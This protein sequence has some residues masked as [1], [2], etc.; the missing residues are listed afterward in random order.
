[1]RAFFFFLLFVASLSSKESS[2]FTFTEHKLELEGG[3]SFDYEALTGSLPIYQGKQKIADVFFVAYSKAGD[4]PARPM[5]FVLPGGPGAAGTLESLIA[6][7]PRRLLTGGEGRSIL[8]PYPIID[9]PQSLLE[10]TDLVFI[11]PVNCGFSRSVEGEEEKEKD[12]LP[13]LYSVEGDIQSLGQ[14]IQAFVSHFDLWD[15]PKYL[16]GGSYGTLRCCGLALDLLKYDILLSGLLL[17]GCALEWAALD[18]ERD[19]ALPDCLLIPT[20]AAT[21]WY[22]ERLWPDKPLLEVVDYARRFAYESYAPAMLQPSRLNRFEQAA[23]F[24]QLA[25]L[26]GLPV[27]TVRRYN[28]RID[29]NLF[30]SEFFASERKVLGG[31]DTRYS[32]DLDSIAPRG[33]DPSY[34]DSRGISAAF[35][36]YLQKELETAPPAF[37]YIGFSWEAF[38]RWQTATY[39]SRG[40]PNFLQR[41]RRA[42]IYNPQMK[43]F[44]GSGYYDCRTPFAATEYSF[45]HLDLPPSYRK[46]LQFAYYE[47]GHGFL[48][49]SASLQK[50]KNDLSDFYGAKTR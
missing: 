16:A 32:G 39:D 23:F 43:I 30:T 44:I 20:F 34:D 13:F 47:A 10:Y 14:F 24:E 31:L 1:M 33:Q 37:S 45:D 48:L 41:L 38:S 21:A 19:R 9:N 28:G 42:L 15:A 35:R 8:P 25:Q 4:E 27:E 36:S 6:F 7:G 3:V 22:H 11:D 5:T 2:P 26:I 46:N 49:D 18:S 29:E 40:E 50:F 12:C 17:H